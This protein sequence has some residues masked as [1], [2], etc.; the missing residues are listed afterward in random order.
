MSDLERAIRDISFDGLKRALEVKH[1]LMRPSRRVMQMDDFVI[2]NEGIITQNNTRDIINEIINQKRYDLLLAFSNNI[3]PYIIGHEIEIIEGIGYAPYFLSWRI[4]LLK[5][6]IEQKR[7]DIAVSFN[8]N[9]PE[10]AEI[11]EEHKTELLQVAEKLITRVTADPFRNYYNFKTSSIFLR[12]CL[13]TNN[14]RG[15]YHFY[16]VAATTDDIFSDRIDDLYSFFLETSAIPSVLMN[17]Q[18][19]FNMF[20]CSLKQMELHLFLKR[21]YIDHLFCH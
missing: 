10:I 19:L 21:N 12:A 14:F 1:L 17:N 16:P 4:D 5:Y 3:E 13:N 9:S 15:L 8:S 7:F 6:F 11:F 20:D 18:T 2:T